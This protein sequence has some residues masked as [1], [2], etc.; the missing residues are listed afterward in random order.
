MSARAE[1]MQWEMPWQPFDGK[2]RGSGW[3]AEMKTVDR[4]RWRARVVQT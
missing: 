3:V 1:I 4:C 2:P